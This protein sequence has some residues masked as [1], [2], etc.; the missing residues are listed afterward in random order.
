MNGSW[1]SDPACRARSRVQHSGS[2]SLGNDVG[3]PAMFSM[4]YW[5]RDNV[6]PVTSPA[7]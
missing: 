3:A 6:L 7:R 1:A 4:Y 5:Q 2:A